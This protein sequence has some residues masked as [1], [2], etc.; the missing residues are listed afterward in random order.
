M[1]IFLTGATGFLGRA[2]CQAAV[3]RGHE[4]LA[5]RRDAYGQDTEQLRWAQGHLGEIPWRSIEGFHPE[6]ALHLAWIATPGVYLQSPENDV[7][8]EQSTA[9]FRGL[10]AQGVAHISGVGTCIEY[11]SSDGPLDEALS[12]IEPTSAYARAKVKTSQSLRT[13]AEAHGRAWS[14]LRVFYPYGEGEHAGRLPSML[15]RL[16]ASDGILALKT[17]DSVK[18]FIHVADAAMAMLMV[19]EHRV[20]GPVNVGTGEGV[21]LQD[22]AME[23]ARIA[24]IDCTRVQPDTQPALDPYPTVIANASRLRQT[25]WKPTVSLKEGLERLWHSLRNE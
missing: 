15:M 23:V 5:L 4:L 18:D 2:F 25:G 10:A 24:G 19:L 9:L 7:L 16:A 3:S 13:L 8:V 20:S 21:R 6:A 11:A 22:L 17:P 14:W 12:P 1:R